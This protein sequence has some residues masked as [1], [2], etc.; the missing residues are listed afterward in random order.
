MKPEGE[1]RAVAAELEAK[2]PGAPVIRIGD[3]QHLAAHGLTER[4]IGDCGTTPL[5]IT[6]DLTGCRVIVGEMIKA[7]QG[8]LRSRERS[9]VITKLEE[10]EMWMLRAQSLE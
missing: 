1:V 8:G 2:E 7:L 6:D 5:E 3:P 4:V 9:L 10:A